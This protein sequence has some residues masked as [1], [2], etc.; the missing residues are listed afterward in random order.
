[1]NCTTTKLVRANFVQH[2]DR[3]YSIQSDDIW[4]Q[5]C[6]KTK[7]DDSPLQST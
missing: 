3:E 6:R 2:L 5:Y 7:Q 4:L 1:M